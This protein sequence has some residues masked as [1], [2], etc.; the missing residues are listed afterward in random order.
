M[1]KED[2]TAELNSTLRLLRVDLLPTVEALRESFQSE[3]ADEG[4][5]G[6]A[7]Q[8]LLQK[9]LENEDPLE[10]DQLELIVTFIYAGL[11]STNGECISCYEE[12]A[13]AC[14]KDV[15]EMLAADLQVVVNNGFCQTV[16]KKNRFILLLLVFGIVCSQLDAKQLM[17]L[18]GE[19]VRYAFSILILSL[20]CI[21]LVF[22]FFSENVT[23]FRKDSFS[24]IVSASL[25]WET[26]AQWAFWQLVHAEGIP[27][28]WL[29]Q[30][31]PKLKSL[32]NAEAATNVLLMLKRIVIFIFYFAMASAELI[33]FFLR[34][35]KMLFLLIYH[36]IKLI[37][38]LH[39][40]FERSN[41]VA[42]FR[43]DAL[44]GVVEFDLSVDN[45]PT[46]TKP[47]GIYPLKGGRHSIIRELCRERESEI[48]TR[49]RRD[50]YEHRS[51]VTNA[52][53]DAVRIQIEAAIWQS[54]GE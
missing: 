22:F 29:T 28:D 12:V 14:D 31:I 52:S 6:E 40:I 25:E 51:R 20:Y 39:L 7:V 16:H 47:P 37:C 9:L 49:R 42:S 18:V 27:V 32:K 33:Q 41:Y 4:E 30:L 36:L 48:E 54:M 19:V 24:Q 44:L 53:P 2:I 38:F 10:D 15:D 13:R 26:T 11:G 35:Q 46:E 50:N 3:D 45:V 21:L 23:L 34:K 1:K 5:K 43:R 17:E 8:R